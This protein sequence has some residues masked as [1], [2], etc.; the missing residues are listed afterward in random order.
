MMRENLGFTTAWAAATAL[1]PVSLRLPRR[2]GPQ[3]AV[4]SGAHGAL[5]MTTPGDTSMVNVKEV[6]A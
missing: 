4:E 1:L 3:A 2:Q 5:A 6:E